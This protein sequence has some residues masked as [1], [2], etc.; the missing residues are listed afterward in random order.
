[1]R[2]RSSFFMPNK[3]NYYLKILT[4]VTFVSQNGV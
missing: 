1:M 4:Q 3:V 2:L